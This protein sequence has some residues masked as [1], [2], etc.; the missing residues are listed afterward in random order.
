LTGPVTGEAVAPAAA[1][2]F[3]DPPMWFVLCERGDLAAMWAVR[4]LRLRGLG[5]VEIL[6]GDEV[7]CALR[8][9]HRVGAAGVSTEMRVARGL[10]ISSSNARGVLNRL[11][12]PPSGGHALAAPADREY[13]RQE[14]LALA[15]SWLHGLPCPVLGRP[16]A[17]GLSGPWLHLS[18]WT[19]LA[20]RAGLRT[21]P[22]RR[23]SRDAGDWL[24]ERAGVDPPHCTVFC[25][26]AGGPGNGTGAATTS[27]D[28]SGAATEAPAEVLA[29]AIRLA[30]LAGA[31]LLG[32]EFGQGWTFAS[33]SPMPDL[34]LGGEPL[35]DLLASSLDGAGPRP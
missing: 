12:L 4:G 26:L 19:S 31:S 15:M 21:A 29:G 2:P 1:S 11:V 14:V 9:E 25:A 6:S 7:A 18:E 5:P 8:I 22:Y 35:L 13:A 10:A 28:A 30:G 27:V 16:T 32:V 17:Q 24:P 20:A 3:V 34:R 33:A 23:S